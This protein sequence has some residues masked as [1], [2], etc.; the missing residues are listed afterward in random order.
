MK[1]IFVLPFDHRANFAQKLFGF[2]EPYSQENIDQVAEY[3]KIIYDAIFKAVEMGIPKDET[4]ILCDEIFGAEILKSARANGLQIM[5]TLEKSGQDELVLEYGDRYI[6]HLKKY[7]ATFAKVL[8]RYNPEDSDKS[9]NQRQ[10]KLLKKI[11]DEVHAVGIKLLIE[12]LIPATKKQLDSIK[13]SEEK[14]KRKFDYKLRGGLCIKMIQEMQN[15]G[16]ECDVWKIEGFYRK[17]DYQKVATQARNN[18]WRENNVGIIILG[19]NETKENVQKWI[20][21]GKNVEGVIGFAVGRTVFWDTLVNYKEGKIDRNMAVKNIAKEYFEFYTL[22]KVQT[23]WH[24]RFGK[25]F[26][27]IFLIAVFF[28]VIYLF[29]E[30][31]K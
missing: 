12:P 28:F 24:T 11:S 26:S 1:N 13:G 10:L 7:D 18:K 5:Q 29:L 25:L 9:K 27:D 6:E 23:F 4:A 21:A 17:S 16:I 22:F 19:R 2:A 14:K 15:A 3:K 31:R 30:A 8:V 20:N